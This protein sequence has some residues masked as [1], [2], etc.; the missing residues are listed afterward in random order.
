MVRLELSE[1][2]ILEDSVC[3]K[4]W[5]EESALTDNLPLN[6]DEVT[7]S[8][9]ISLMPFIANILTGLFR[10][11]FFVF[12]IVPS[13]VR[14]KVKAPTSSPSPLYFKVFWGFTE[15]L[16]LARCSILVLISVFSKISSSPP[17]SLRLPLLK[18]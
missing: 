11:K 14:V 1:I 13:P 3:S 7:E 2:S 12:S 18:S 10:I 15:M 8:P 9:E 4:V 17:F 6:N 16:L 5:I